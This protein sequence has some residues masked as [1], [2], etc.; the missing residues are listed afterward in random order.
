LRSVPRGEEKGEE[1]GK[2][3][4]GVLFSGGREKR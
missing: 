2:K 1:K 4:F 3:K